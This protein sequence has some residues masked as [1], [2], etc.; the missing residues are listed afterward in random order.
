M[1]LNDEFLLFIIKTDT[2]IKP[3]KEKRRRTIQL[4]TEWTSQW[5]FSLFADTLKLEKNKWLLAFNLTKKFFLF[6]EKL[7]KGLIFSS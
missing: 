7:N 6:F 5:I 4:Y 2:V 3:A 1:F